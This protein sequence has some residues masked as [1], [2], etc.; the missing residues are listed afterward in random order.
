MLLLFIF[1][2]LITFVFPILYNE[3][4]NSIDVIIVSVAFL[5]SIILETFFAASIWYLKNFN[6]NNQLGKNSNLI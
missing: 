2:K 6:L 3:T 1:K 4:S 5:L